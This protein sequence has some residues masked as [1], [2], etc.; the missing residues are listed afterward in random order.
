MW[1]RLP[2]GGSDSQKQVKFQL[3]YGSYRMLV[4]TYAWSTTTLASGAQ[5]SEK[6][7]FNMGNFSDITVYT[8]QAVPDTD[9]MCLVF[10]IKKPEGLKLYK[11]GTLVHSE[12]NA[13][14]NWDAFEQT[15][16]GEIGNGNILIEVLEQGDGIAE[17]YDYRIYDYAF[18]PE[19]AAGYANKEF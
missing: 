4:L 16:K 9:F 10:S 13:D 3:R 2:A 5:N 19:N 11:N 7:M 8:D 14:F 17:I 18:T 6:F 15:W 1:L 12:E